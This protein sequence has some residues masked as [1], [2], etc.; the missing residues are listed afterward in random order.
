VIQASFE[1]KI[2]AAFVAAAVVLVAVG[3][4]ASNS[5]NR[6]IGASD[7]VQRTERL[8]RQ[9]EETYSQIADA[10]TASRGYVLT[11]D[12]GYLA[13]FRLATDSLPA[14]ISALR[15]VAVTSPRRRDYLRRLEPLLLRRLEAVR[16]TVRLRATEGAPAAV[17]HIRTG[18]GKAI[19]DTIRALVDEM[20]REEE[21]LR[22]AEAREARASVTRVTVAMG[23]GLLVALAI[24]LLAAAVAQRELNAHDR[25]ERALRQAKEAAEGA[26]RAK[27]DFLARMSHELRTP[28]NSVIGFSNVLLGRRGEA[29]ETPKTR[30]YLERIRDNGMH[31]LVL[32][33]DLLDMA[34]IEVGRIA[35]NREQVA[36]D[37][38]V[39]GVVGSFEVDAR[40]R[41]LSLRAELPEGLTPLHT[42][43][44]RLRQVLSNLV[45]NALKFTERG[46][47]LVRVTADAATG[48][49][50]RIDVEDTGIGIP[51]DRRTAVFEAFE[52]GTT[53]ADRRSHEGAGLGLAIARALCDLLG[54]RLEL[55]SEVGVGSTFSVQL[56]GRGEHGGT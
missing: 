26:N 42:D 28:L 24:S 11:G 37:E 52:Q 55:R 25:A 10:E 23:V 9:L 33:N 47:V 45:G 50:S 1:R 40:A 7:A 44:A 18:R 32:I 15:E 35:V 38:L 36:L 6:L 20:E 21:A 4:L 19:M 43:P 56:A 22:H 3:A 29:L 39:R 17:A 48:A 51:E 30:E 2:I 53:G 31:L 5:M 49:P 16:T 54:Y 46:H 27:S 34:R 13:D 8:L 14:E 41:G 12:A